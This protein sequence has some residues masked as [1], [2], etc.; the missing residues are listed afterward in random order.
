MCLV[1]DNAGRE[2][3]ADLVLVDHLLAAGLAE[4]VTLHVKPYP[5][6]VSDATTADVVGCLRR[7]ASGPPL[8]HAQ[9]PTTTHVL[10]WLLHGADSRDFPK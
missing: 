4:R 5:Y 9:R 3:L 10:A 2:L 7:L 8:I 1:A 6:Y